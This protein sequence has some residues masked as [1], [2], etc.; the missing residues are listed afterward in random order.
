MPT[1]VKDIVADYLKANGYDGLY[2]G[3]AECGCDLAD[4]FPCECMNAHVCRPGY[5]K[6]CGGCDEY[7]WCISNEKDA[8]CWRDGVE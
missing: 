6:L 4:L 5:K 3:D 7:N 8:E 1:N 2:N